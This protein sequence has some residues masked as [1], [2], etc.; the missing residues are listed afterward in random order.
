MSSNDLVHYHVGNF[1]DKNISPR[2]ALGH[3]RLLFD[4]LSVAAPE[5]AAA[6]NSALP[7]TLVKSSI[8]IYRSRHQK[9][10]WTNDG[11]F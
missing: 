5:R 11:R 1:G 9:R 4:F 2:Y 7:D 10:W 6:H 3:F 8:D